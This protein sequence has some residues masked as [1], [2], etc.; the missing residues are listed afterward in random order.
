VRAKYSKKI[1]LALLNQSIDVYFSYLLK[2]NTKLITNYLSVHPPNEVPA[3][4]GIS[5]LTKLYFLKMYAYSTHRDGHD[6]D[7]QDQIVI[8]KIKIVI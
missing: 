2:Y 8:L 4:K 7:L 5:I 3:K 1:Y 6:L